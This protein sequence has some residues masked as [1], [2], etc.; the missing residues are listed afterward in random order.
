MGDLM[1]TKILI[2]VSSVM[3]W[4]S[5]PPKEKKEGEEVDEGDPEEPD[6]EPEEIKDDPV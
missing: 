5:T 1:E 6:S 4:S 3:V 2:F